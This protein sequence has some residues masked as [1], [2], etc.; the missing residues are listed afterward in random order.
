MFSFWVSKK[1]ENEQ[2]TV[3][4]PAQNAESSDHAQTRISVEAD[5]RTRL[6]PS[7]PHGYLSPDDP[8]V[9]YPFLSELNRNK[10]LGKLRNPSS[11]LLRSWEA[12]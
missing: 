9:C 11:Q 10:T 2:R 1:D 7:L 3:D 12:Q 6:L 5:E 8:A 4:A